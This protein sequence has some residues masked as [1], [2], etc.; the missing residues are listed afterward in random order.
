MTLIVE[1]GTGV[2]GANSYVSEANHVSFCALYGVTVT[3]QQATINLTKAFDYIETRKGY[4]GQK[5]IN[6][7][8]TIFPR[9]NLWL[10]GVL[11]AENAVPWQA[12]RAQNELALCIFQGIDPLGVHDSSIASETFG[13]WSTTYKPGSDNRPKSV[14]MLLYLLPLLKD[15]VSPIH[16]KVETDRERH[17]NSCDGDNNLFGPDGYSYYE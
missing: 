2:T 15:G 11:I 7:Q 4:R 1:N 14:R 5:V 3:T 9:K 6:T 17:I 12:P 10:D 8:P 16:F 13:P